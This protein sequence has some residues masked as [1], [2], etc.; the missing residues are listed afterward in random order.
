MWLILLLIAVL[1]FAYFYKNIDKKQ[2]YWKER[3]VPGPDPTFLV[4]NM[5]ENMVK[6]K[7]LGQILI[8][9]YK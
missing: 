7:S 8:D 9:I 2:S 3:N 4:G 6:K 5:L 1:L